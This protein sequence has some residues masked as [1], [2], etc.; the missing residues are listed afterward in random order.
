MAIDPRALVPDPLDAAALERCARD[1]A[2]P[3]LLAAWTDAPADDAARR[4]IVAALRIDLPL[5]VADPSLLPVCLYNRTRWLEPL[6][7]WAERW[8]D[9][10][11]GQSW[12]RALR[13]PE[14]A[15]G[16]PL[17]EEYRE[18]FDGV[19]RIRVDRDAL[20][21]GSE[22]GA[23]A[24][25][26]A[27]G[28]RL[29]DAEAARRIA[30]SEPRFEVDWSR[31]AGDHWG[32]VQVRDR[33]AGTS[34]DLSVDDDSSFGEVADLPTGLVAAGWCG[35]YE[36]V[37]CRVD[38]PARS[39]RWRTLLPQ[40][41]HA[42]AVDPSGRLLAVAGERDVHVLDAS[43]GAVL[44]TAA[45]HAQSLALGEDGATLA[46]R[47]GELVRVWDVA[48]LGRAA[49]LAGADGGWVDAAFSPDGARLL[50]GESLWDARTGESIARLSLDGPGYLEGGPPEHG[51]RLGDARLVEMAPLRGVCVYSTDDGRLLVRDP[52]RLYALRDDVEISPDCR[53][54]AHGRADHSSDGP[55]ER[56]LRRVDD[57]APVASLGL[58]DRGHT[59]FA[60]DGRRLFS[61]AGPWMTAWR[62]PEGVRETC[63]EHPAPVTGVAVAHH[64]GAV[65]TAARDGVVRLWDIA[66]GA[67][68]GARPDEVRAAGSGRWAIAPDTLAR[69]VGWLGF[70][71]AGHPYTTRRRRG[72]VEIVAGE[73]VVAR[74][75][76][77]HPLVADPTG[78]RW[79]SR[80]DLLALEGC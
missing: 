31:R 54:Y 1:G 13:A 5:L 38:L 53:Y 41:V 8:R 60:P 17:L 12:A 39:A 61:A 70:A 52:S 56:T 22:A 47:H 37:V 48:A 20:A 49:G 26:R 80:H 27:S 55:F 45:L 66:S 30:G 25:D 4:L 50:T 10:R 71:A 40:Q 19:T 69:A 11:A 21:L 6:R 35:D 77:H 24:W 16:G 57:G 72:L 29:A 14:H 7:A 62:I 34:I 63:F 36:G 78:T 74:V 42:V 32:R 73:R 67:L 43:S 68:L 9:A 59:C 23:I 44:V 65:L 79:A 76:T 2:L 33:A 58:A 18:R 75:A 46:T 15:P 64:G 3:A 51:R 28:R